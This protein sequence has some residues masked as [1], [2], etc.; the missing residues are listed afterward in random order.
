MPATASTTRNSRAGPPNRGDAALEEV[1]LP[2]LERVRQTAHDIEDRVRSTLTP[3]GS[4]V[5]ALRILVVDDLP[6][7]ADS[8]AVVLELIGC[9]VRACY[10][11]RAALRIAGEFDPQVCLLDL[12]MPEMSGLELGAC[13]RVAAKGKPLVLIATTALGTDEIK[14]RTKDAGFDA[15]LTKPIDVSV[16]IEAVSHLWESVNKDSGPQDSSA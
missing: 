14:L 11:A 15:H 9:S 5:S 4:H 12:V 7:A 10:D 1:F 6:D 3:S 2:A 13:L 16:L 8:L